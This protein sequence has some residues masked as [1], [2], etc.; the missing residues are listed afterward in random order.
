[1]PQIKTQTL[2]YPRM[3]EQRELK[4]AVEAYW[5][6]KGTTEELEAVGRELRKRH[7][8]AQQEAGIDLIPCNDFSE[9]DHV[10]DMSC[11]LGNLP[12]RF[13]NREA[14]VSRDQRFAVARGTAEHPAAEMTKWFDTNYHYI[15]PELDRTTQ[16]RLSCD[17]VFK[18]FQEARELGITAKPVL[19]GPLT[20]LSLAKIHGEDF[21]R[22]ELLEQLTEVYCEILEK[23]SHLGADWVQL[24]EPVLALDLEPEVGQLFQKT[25]RRLRSSDTILRLQ[26]TSYFGPLDDNLEILRKL[27]VDAIHLDAVSAP[28]ELEPMMAGF[29]EAL[30]LS[31]GIVSGRNIW[32]ND[33]TRSLGVLEKV[34]AKLGDE[35]LIVSASSSFLHVP[36]SL[37]HESNLDPEVGNWMA[38]A[39]EKLDELSFLR[40]FLEGNGSIETLEQNRQAHLDRSQSPRLIQE[41][42]RQRLLKL[43]ADDVN[44][45]SAFPVRQ[46]AQQRALELPDF[47]TTT[48]GSFPQTKEIRSARAMWRK[49]KLKDAD[50]ERFLKNELR[51][52][53][54]FQEKSGLDLLVHGEFE[55]TDMVEFFGEKLDGFLFTENG[56]VQS[57][58]SRCVKPPVIYGDVSRPAPMTVANSA[59]AQSLTDKPVKGML[60]GPITILQW[61]FVRD[62]QPRAHTARQIA[63]AIRDEVVDLED[64]GLAAIQIDE[65]A[66]REGLPLRRKYWKTY[67]RWAVDAFRLSASGVKDE[68][69]IHTHMCYCEF[70]D[71]IVSIAELDAD[72][73][74][75]ETSRSNMELLEAFSDYRYPNEIG[76][77]VYD[78]HSPRI[79]SVESMVELMEK[80]AAVIPRQ[81]L[82]VNPDCGL[83]TR[84]W[85]EVSP[86]LEAL[87][88]CAR[89]LRATHTPELAPA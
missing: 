25:Y 13:E 85:E 71:I 57:Y 78:I 34:R 58:G 69:Q 41:A 56:W 50:Y 8:L 46:H 29:P 2:G 55:R 47:P 21:D 64:A 68:T 38:F 63:L 82:W 83:K 4:K 35:R 88:E 45:R 27:P 73:I 65:P 39:D 24:D 81:Q 60:T 20:Y 15:V 40:D 16:F 12:R 59:F 14:T 42:V 53:I 77:G 51:R 89:Q 76:P 32:K 23:L 19:L 80:A 84:R 11:L 43:T 67:L 79:P 17:K 10:L 5:K 54:E 72:V 61:S 30:T 49:G 87:V 44:R 74:T 33:F 62:D 7:W 31:V 66:L 6:G 75:I 48:I 3:G 26:V 86:A 9:Y 28:G 52:C 36:H 70:N 18:E 22:F 37:R 1:M